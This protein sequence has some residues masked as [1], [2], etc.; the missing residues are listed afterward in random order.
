MRLK[1][2][3]IGFILLTSNLANA[4]FTQ[5]QDALEKTFC[6]TSDVPAYM[7][8]ESELFNF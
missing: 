6:N 1:L 3:A 5:H 8:N 2:T 7:I 4:A